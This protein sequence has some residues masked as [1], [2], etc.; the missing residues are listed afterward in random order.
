MEKRKNNHWVRHLKA[1]NKTNQ[2]T[3][4]TKQNKTKNPK[5]LKVGGLPS[6]GEPF[7]I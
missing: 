3:N 5:P 6:S 1:K 7:F 4:K 2:K